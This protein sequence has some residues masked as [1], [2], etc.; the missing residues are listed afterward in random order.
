MFGFFVFSL[1]FVA[2]TSAG[3]S[4]LVV[5]EQHA[6]SSHN[7]EVSG[8]YESAGY[9][10]AEII[11]HFAESGSVRNGKG[12]S[13]AELTSLAHNS[14]VQAKN[15][16][17]NQHTAGSQAAFGIKSSLASAAIGAAQTA[18]AALVGKQAIIQNLKRQVVDGQQQ[19]QAEIA[20]LQQLEAVAQVAAQSSQDSHALL[21]SLNAALAAAQAGASHAEQAA[22]EASNAAAS[23][24]GMVEEA[25]QNV[26]QILSQ[27][28]SAISELQQTE[29]SAIK[30]AEAAQ[31]AQSNAAAAGLAVAAAS[32]K[33]GHSAGS[34][35]GYH[36]SG[37][38]Y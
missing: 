3:T 16:V 17:R 15:A 31:I 23:Q 18:Q 8:G 33:D 1:F 21:N 30:A 11:D 9:G 20:Q 22:A 13:G 36:H 28:Q 29:V 25:K 19:L 26:A 5:P 34:N 7:L 38:H 6:Q 14:A 35:A 24:H 37:H 4:K 27:L 10:G 12:T 2:L 32:A